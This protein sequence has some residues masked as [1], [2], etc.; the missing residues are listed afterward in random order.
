MK[1]SQIQSQIITYLEANGWLVVKIMQSNKNGWPD[2]QAFKDSRCIF[3]E[4]KTPSGRL[5][6]L[7]KYRITQLTDKGFNCYVITSLNNLINELSTTGST[8]L[9]GIR[10]IDYFDR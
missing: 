8:K 7:Q 5:S 2:L 1:E 6:E 10:P 9:P 4:V 3:I